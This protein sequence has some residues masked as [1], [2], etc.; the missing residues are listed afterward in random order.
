MNEFY[1][2]CK[3]A[4]VSSM[5]SSRDTNAVAYHAPQYRLT[6]SGQARFKVGFWAKQSS[7]FTT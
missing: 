4:A 6:A 1:V 3:A 5:A 7:L 2:I